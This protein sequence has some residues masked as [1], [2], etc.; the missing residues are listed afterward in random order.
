MELRRE[1]PAPERNKLRPFPDDVHQGRPRGI[2]VTTAYQY[3]ATANTSQG[4]I[5]VGA[6]GHVTPKRFSIV[7]QAQAPFG[8]AG[9]LPG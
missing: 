3:D 1:N 4:Q 6:E 8:A 7:F 5:Q 2:K 9:W